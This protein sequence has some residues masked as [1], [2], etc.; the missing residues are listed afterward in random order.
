MKTVIRYSHLII[1]L[2]LGGCFGKQPVIKSGLEGKPLPSFEMLLL[3]STK[4]SS[5]NIGSGKQSILFFLNPECPYCKAQTVEILDNIKS[6][7][8]VQIYMIT[9]WPYKSMNQY[10]EHYNLN[11][12][13]N[14]IV[15][16]DHENY[17]QNRF[18]INSVPYIA[19]YNKE[20]ILKQVLVGKSKTSLLKDILSD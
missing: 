6:F 15:G 5:E 18:K 12:Y 9:N 3:D 19:I 2:T 11:K 1:L 14:I 13:P 8:T 4:I 17:L 7:D 16:Y 10:Y 20:K